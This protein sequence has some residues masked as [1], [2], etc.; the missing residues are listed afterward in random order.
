[1]IFHEPKKNSA[2]SPVIGTILLV[3]IAVVLVA[4]ILVVVMGFAGNEEGKKVGMNA[5]PDNFETAKAKLIIYGGESV[6]DLIKLEMIDQD[7]PRGEYVELWNSSDGELTVGFPYLTKGNVAKPSENMTIYDTR[8]NIR[9]TF[10][11]GKEVILL[12]QPMTFGN[13]EGPPS[14]MGLAGYI[15]KVIYVDTGRTNGESIDL[16]DRHTVETEVPKYYGG[17]GDRTTGIPAYDKDDPYN[18]SKWIDPHS[19]NWWYGYIIDCTIQLQYADNPSSKITKVTAWLRPKGYVI[20]AGDVA[21]LGEYPRAFTTSTTRVDF[22][23]HV[24]SNVNSAKDG[25]W[26]LTITVT[27]ENDETFSQDWQLT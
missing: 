4:I 18:Q 9:G 5:Q 14:P 27:N 23:S 7:S 10:T 1:M 25:E 11:D 3:A 8:V 24:G 21:W 17:S 6:S 16:T 26:T 20:N 15:D 12:V 22:S 19:W 13:V 2:V